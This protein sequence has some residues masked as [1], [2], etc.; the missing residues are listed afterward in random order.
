[1]TMYGTIGD[2]IEMELKRIFGELISSNENALL[3][4]QFNRN[5]GVNQRSRRTC[6]LIILG[7]GGIGSNVVDMITSI[8]DIGNVLLVD[9]DVVELSNLNRTAYGYEDIGK[10]KTLCCHRIIQNRNKFIK[11]FMLNDRLDPETMLTIMESED[12]DKYAEYRLIV[13][14]FVQSVKYKSAFSEYDVIVVDCR[15]DAYN[16]YDEIEKFLGS[17]IFGSM[18]KVSFIRGAYDG[19]SITLDPNPEKTAVWTNTRA[20]YQQVV[21]HGLPSRMIALLVCNSI[22]GRIN[23]I[24]SRATEIGPLTYDYYNTELYTRIGKH[25]MKILGKNRRLVELLIIFNT[26]EEMKSKTDPIKYSDML[27]SLNSNLQTVAHT[28]IRKMIST[29]ASCEYTLN[30]IPEI[31]DRLLTPEGENDGSS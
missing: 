12:S 4:E 1:M 11:V 29:D 10:P 31:I 5:E 2:S 7:L 17:V 20:G 22:R 18:K 27:N 19:D 15:D 9:D 8:P 14:A 23:D 21:S 26:M 13:E 24:Y 3:I 6:G 28:A 25:A 16:D 30:R